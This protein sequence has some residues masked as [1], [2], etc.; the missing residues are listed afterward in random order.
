MHEQRLEGTQNA[1]T[2]EVTL[3]FPSLGSRLQAWSICKATFYRSFHD[4]H[5]K[6]IREAMQRSHT[7]LIF[8]LRRAVLPPQVGSCANPN[9]LL[10]LS[11]S[12]ALHPQV[13]TKVLYVQAC[14]E[15]G[16]I[17]EMGSDQ[18]RHQWA[19]FPTVWDLAVRIK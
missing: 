15:Q 2:R 1:M 16:V 11:E 19:M 17:F 3:F 8:G 5:P 9:K 7:L 18:N 10:D 13:K 14:C 4:S 12:Q 6:A